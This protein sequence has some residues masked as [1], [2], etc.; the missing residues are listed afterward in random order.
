YLNEL[1]I[2]LLPRRDPHVE[3][4][5]LYESTL[6]ALRVGVDEAAALRIFEK[7]LLES[8]GY[9]LPLTHDA[10]SGEP[11]DSARSYRFVPDEGPIETT[12]GVAEGHCLVSGATLVALAAERLDEPVARREARAILRLAIERCLEGRGLRS[13]DVLMSMRRSAPSASGRP[14]PPAAGDET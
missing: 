11:V 4:F 1:L 7:R 9:G 5:E 8:V 10:R 13:R 6:A 2:R 12:P 3:V 14:V